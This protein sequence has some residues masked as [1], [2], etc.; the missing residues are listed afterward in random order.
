M[1]DV[2]DNLRTH[3]D[4]ELGGTLNSAHLERGEFTAAHKASLYRQA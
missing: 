3:P 1:A 2:L 4:A